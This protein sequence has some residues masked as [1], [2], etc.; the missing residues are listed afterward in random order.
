MAE[1]EG[2]AVALRVA[3]PVQGPLPERGPEAPDLRAAR[4]P[5]WAPHPAAPIRGRRLP[6]G[7]ERRAPRP[8]RTPTRTGARTIQTFSP[9]RR[10]VRPLRRHKPNGIR[11]S[12]M[13][14]TGCLSAVR[15][16]GPAMRIRNNLDPVQEGPA[17]VRASPLRRKG[18]PA[19]LAQ[20][21]N[22][23]RG[24]SPQAA[25][26]PR[27]ALFLA[28]GSARAQIDQRDVDGQPGCYACEQP[29]HVERFL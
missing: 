8:G 27:F 7:W 21:A 24:S 3:E 25:L 16:P 11:A 10:T 4:G 5:E 20:A 28:A 29:C 23:R 9:R 18:R 19:A 13:R 14:R 26:D 12:D 17:A 6:P 2:Q 1:E 22:G 15:A